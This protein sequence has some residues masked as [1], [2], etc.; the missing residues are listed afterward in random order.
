MTHELLDFDARVWLVIV[1]LIAKELS[2]VAG[3]FIL[4]HKHHILVYK[5]DLVDVG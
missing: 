5:A 1:D 3:I 4:N 2:F